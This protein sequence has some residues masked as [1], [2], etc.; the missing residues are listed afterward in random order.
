MLRMSNNEP[1][2]QNATAKIHLVDHL[3]PTKHPAFVPLAYVPR[4]LFM[5]ISTKWWMPV[6]QAEFKNQ[7]EL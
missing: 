1:S 7:N 6:I 5:N 3:C 4:D 2:M